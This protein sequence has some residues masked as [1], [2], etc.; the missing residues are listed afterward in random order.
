MGEVYRARDTKLK[1]EVALKVLPEAFA[2]DP[3][4]MA[5]FQREA[6]VLAS[7]NH[8]NIAQIYGIEDRALVMELVPGKTLKGP[9]PVATAIE[10]ARQIA[11]ALAVAHAAGIVHRDIKPA[12][13]IVTP[14]GQVKILD[15]GLAKLQERGPGPMSETRTVEPALTETGVVMGT[16]AYMSPE[17]ARAEEVDAR[18]DLFSFGA[19]LYEMVTGRRPFRKTL[20]WASPPAHMLQPELRQIVLKLLEVDRELR[21]QTA[22]DVAADL[23]RLQRALEGTQTSRR[24]WTAAAAASLVIVLAL[25]AAYAIV[26]RAPRDVNVRPAAVRGEFSRVTSQPGVEWF[27]SLSPDGKWLVYA[28]DAG[29]TNRHIYLQSVN[30]QN[31]LDLT[32]DSTADDDQPAFSPDGELIAFRS[33]RDG[34]GI[35]VMGRTGE[36]A[37]RVTRLGFNPSWSP[38]GTQLAFAT[39]SFALYPQNPAPGELWTVTVNTGE[40]RRLLDRDAALPSW[41]PHNHRIAFTRFMSNRAQGGIWTLPVKGGTATPVTRDPA[42]N[43]DPVWSPD[44]KYLYFVSDRGG[45]MNLWRVPV[46]EASG[47]T[48]AEPEP[49]TTPAAYLAH[50]TLSADGKRIAYSSVLITANIQQLTLDRSIALKGDPAWATSGSRI[51]ANPDPSPNGEWVA[52]YSLTQP[53]GQLYVSHPDGTGLRQVT[54]DMAVDRVP[55]WSPDGK[56]IAF[57]SNR[58]GRLALWKIRPDGS[59]LQQI[60][61][62]GGGFYPTWS[63]DGSRIAAL[64]GLEGP[65]GKDA[66]WIF[67]PNRPWKQQAAEVLPPFDRPPRRFRA[68]SWSAD[69]ERIAGNLDGEGGGG[70]ATYSLRSHKYESLTDFGEW[71]AWLPDDRH[72]LF[73][74]DGKAF[75]VVDTRSKQ[76]RKIFS[77]TRDVIGPPRLTRDAT[78]AYFSRRVTESDI[79]LLT[80]K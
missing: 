10:Y 70:I 45:S 12:N 39:A 30:G 59:E 51:W 44:G 15:F 67:D 66:V 71:P 73:V 52:F 28:A 68:T 42:Q 79:W 6:E 8:P 22:A 54:N 34:G 37:R 11:S 5:R 76:V 4:R 18:T 74:A 33:S 19:V 1:R 63:S 26:W 65:P 75:F 53:E 40:A 72:L 58:S 56:W 29:V 14:E 46:D 32:R 9:L 49:V 64:Y 35:F 55:R 7:L 47:K 16:A 48:L 3:A 31:P 20:D 43:W 78:K 80:L 24:W 17:Q 36:A 41:S 61:E 2:G 38:D 60:S 57:F 50:P 27:P 21:Y 25:I 62:G 77:V 23:K 69:G 13:V